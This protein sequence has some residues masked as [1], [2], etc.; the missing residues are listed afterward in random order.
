[1]LFL[2]FPLGLPFWKSSLTLPAS[3]PIAI[4]RS[5]YIF[6]TGTP[7][8]LR[9]LEA[10]LSVS[11]IIA[12]KMCSVPISSDLNLAAS[13]AALSSICLTLGV[14]PDGSLT[15]TTLSG[16]ISWHTRLIIFS[17]VIS[18]LRRTEDASPPSALIS[19]IRRCSE[20]I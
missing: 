18:L 11:F 6:L 20:P 15:L 5:T 4:R 19:P 10:T 14:Y 12:I 3:S 8:V 1:M 7:I 2:S 17:S 13:L 9:S 16:A